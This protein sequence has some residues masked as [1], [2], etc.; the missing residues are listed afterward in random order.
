MEANNKTSPQE[1]VRR[2]EGLLALAGQLK[3]LL[4]KARGQVEKPTP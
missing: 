4:A 1:I 2:V 3:A